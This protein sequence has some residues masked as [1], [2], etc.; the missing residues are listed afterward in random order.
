MSDVESLSDASS[1]ES[2]SCSDCSDFEDDWLYD[3]TNKHSAL[4]IKD[5]ALA[6]LGLCLRHNLSTECVNDILSLVDLHLPD[7]NRSCS[8]FSNVKSNVAGIKTADEVQFIEYCEQCYAL[9]PTD[10]TVFKC[11]TELCT[12]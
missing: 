4:T 7:N 2:G 10:G 11:P 3:R 8:T 12:G 5:H 6:V 9:W 1:C